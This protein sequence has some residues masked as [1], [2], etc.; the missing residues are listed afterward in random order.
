MFLGKQKQQIF[1]G[2]GVVINKGEKGADKTALTYPTQATSALCVHIQSMNA[3]A[4]RP[5]NE[6]ADAMQPR[7]LLLYRH[8]SR[9]VASAVRSQYAFF[10][11]K[12]TCTPRES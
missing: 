3:H 7:A 6:H 8:E 10:L 12:S 5:Q 11:V 1:N 9:K 2:E 4:Q